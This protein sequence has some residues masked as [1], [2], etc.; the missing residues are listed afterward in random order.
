[1]QEENENKQA[2][3][4][5][6]TSKQDYWFAKYVIFSV[7]LI[8][9]LIIALRILQIKRNKIKEKDDGEN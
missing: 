2:I 8:I 9:V 6:I 4:E 1:M 3:E 5:N 7:I